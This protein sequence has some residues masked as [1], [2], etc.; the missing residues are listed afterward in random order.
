MKNLILNNFGMKASAV[1]ISVFLWFFVTSRGQSELSLDATLEFKDIPLELGIVSSSAKSVTLT[2][3]GQERFMKNLNA[4]DIRVFVDLSRAKQGEWI[5][6]I[7]KDNV[8]L[9]FAMSATNVSPSSVKV[10]LEEIISKKVLVR[11]QVIGISEKGS[12]VS[13][14]VEPKRVTIKGLKSD[15][16]K[17][18]ALRTEVFNISEIRDSVTE[19]LMLDTSGMNITPEV[20]KVKV[21]ITFMENKK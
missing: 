18:D 20:S 7:D 12:Q 21:T 8:K 2:V 19:E 6:P 13:I 10:K 4:A 16:Q 17:I 1:L 14:A 11:P 15:I 9:P 5:F 3:R